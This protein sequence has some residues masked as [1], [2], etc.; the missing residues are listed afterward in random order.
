MFNAFSPLAGGNDFGVFN[1]APESPIRSRGEDFTRPLHA[2]AIY[3]F[4][5]VIGYV[6]GF[7]PQFNEMEFALMKGKT[8]YGSWVGAHPFTDA[9]LSFVFPDMQGGFQKVRG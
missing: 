2:H 1:R 7:A 5:V 6:S 4:P 8:P 3:P 9:Q